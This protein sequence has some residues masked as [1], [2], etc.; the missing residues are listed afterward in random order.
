MSRTVLFMV[1]TI[2]SLNILA[3][4]V[5]DVPHA[6]Y[7]HFVLH[8]GR[9]FPLKGRFMANLFV[10]FEP[11]GHSKRH[12]AR[13]ESEKVDVHAKYRDALN[14]GVGGHESDNNSGLPSY[15]IAGTPEA[16]HWKQQHPGGQ[17]RSIGCPSHLREGNAFLVY[18]HAYYWIS[19]WDNRD[20]NAILP[21]PD[22]QLHIWQ[23]RAAILRRSSEK[24]Q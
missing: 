20:Q 22:P 1:S 14:R 23:P 3:P 19:L 8:L 4:L 24:F 11:V 2:L 18:T 9:P 10:H 6:I 5:R 7:Y 21:L 15:I 12:D 17:V 16:S 13:M